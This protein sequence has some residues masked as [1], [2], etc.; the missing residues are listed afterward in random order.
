MLEGV[1][2]GLLSDSH[3]FLDPAI[4]RYFAECDE[5]WHAGDFGKVAQFDELN[6]F[7]PTRGVWGN[8]DGADVRRAMPRD[9]Y[10]ECA[11]L[12]VYMTH[13]G[14]YPGVYDKRARVAIDQRKPGL[15]ICGHSHIYSFHEMD[16]IHVVNQP[17]VGYPLD[18]G[19]IIGWLDTTFSRDGAD[20]KF[21]TIDSANPRNGAITSLRW[22][23]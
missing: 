16:G 21:R 11:G 18:E 6:A 2:I 10:W 20:I 1:R 5:I 22:R 14:G 12:F 19:A 7:K 8:I 13:I 23:T 9:L 4:F 15:F 3:G 17:A